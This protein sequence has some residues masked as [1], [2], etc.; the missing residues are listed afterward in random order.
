[1]QKPVDMKPRSRHALQF[2]A[3]SFTPSF[4]AQP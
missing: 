2:A 4:G 1:M 3:D